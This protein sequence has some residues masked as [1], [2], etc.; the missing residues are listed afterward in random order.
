[1]RA[2]D[3]AQQL[4]RLP[5]QEAMRSALARSAARLQDA[6]VEALSE[7]PG[8]DHDAPWLRTGALRASISQR[9]D[10]LEVVVGSDSE[11]A[12]FQERGTARVPPRPFLA[13]AAARMA[14]ELARAI[15]ADVAAAIGGR[16]PDEH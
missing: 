13:P 14:P 8:G 4:R 7:A 3:L 6:V 16:A 9:A 12:E 2:R 1:M 15:G 11:V 10:A 5:V